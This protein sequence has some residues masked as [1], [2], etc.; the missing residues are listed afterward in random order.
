LI[1]VNSRFFA[2]AMPQIDCGPFF[3]LCGTPAVAG[4][5]GP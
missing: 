1:A 2:C 3:N 4:A 5:A